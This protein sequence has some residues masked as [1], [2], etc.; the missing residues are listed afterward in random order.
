MNIIKMTAF[1]RAGKEERRELISFFM[2]GNLLMD[3]K[4]LRTLRVRKAFR[5]DPEIPGM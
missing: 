4:G 3:L 5:F 2:L 1:P